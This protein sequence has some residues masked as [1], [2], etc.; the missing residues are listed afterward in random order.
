MAASSQ[1]L[2]EEAFVR[3]R[4]KVVG[5]MP[6]CAAAARIEMFS[7]SSRRAISAAMARVFASGVCS[8]WDNICPTWG[9]GQVPG[10]GHI[11]SFFVH[12]ASLMGMDARERSKWTDATARTLRAERGARDWSREVMADRSGI[13]ISTLRRL[14]G[15]SR[16]Q[17]V[18]QIARAC[19]AFG[20]SMGEFFN[21]V[22]SR[23]NEEA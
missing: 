18:T 19:E 7:E 23:L 21:R 16:V 12:C 15:G 10:V 4:L 6:T 8:M 2:K 3:R 17:D 20:L 11:W 9:R 14:E 1:T 22:E 13:P 5:G